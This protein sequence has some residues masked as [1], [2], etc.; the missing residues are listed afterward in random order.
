MGDALGPG[1]P[2]SLVELELGSLPREWGRA[3]RASMGLTLFHFSL[4]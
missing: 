4:V 1:R 3:E 2:Q